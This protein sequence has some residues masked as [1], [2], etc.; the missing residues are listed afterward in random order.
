MPTQ[1]EHCPDDIWENASPEERRCYEQGHDWYYDTCSRCGQRK[2]VPDYL[3]RKRDEESRRLNDK[4][5]LSG[6]R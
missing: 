3:I 2:N 4:L 6:D 5:K 1:P